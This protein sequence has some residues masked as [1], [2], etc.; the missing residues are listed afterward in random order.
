[1]RI[2]ILNMWCIMSN[3]AMPRLNVYLD[4]ITKDKLKE[5]SDNENRPI[6]RQIKH[7]LE[8]YL[9]YKDKVK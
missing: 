9:K 4:Q 2:N 5:I 7:M 3:E 8:F 6:S 1:M